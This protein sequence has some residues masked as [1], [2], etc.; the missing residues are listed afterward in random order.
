MPTPFDFDS[1]TQSFDL[2]LLFPGQV[3]KEFFVNQALTL[4]DSLLSQTL[5]ASEST[6]PSAALDGSAFRATAGAT[7]EWAGHED[8]IAVRVAGAWHFVAPFAGMRLHDQAQGQIIVYGT[9]WETAGGISAPQGG[10]NADTEART[11]IAE[12]I[13]ALQKVAILP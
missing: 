2:P 1:T 8:E 3:Q 7:G 10:S 4:I 13:A 9:Q 12:L 6:P 5:V 11:A